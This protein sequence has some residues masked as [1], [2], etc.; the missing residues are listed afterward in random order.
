MTSPYTQLDKQRMTIA[1]QRARLDDLE[2][3]VAALR[4]VLTSPHALDAAH[5]RGRCEVLTHE[6]ALLRA[7]N[8]SWAKRGEG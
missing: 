2:A 5:Y 8:A 6:N 7:A 3:E 1:R 4:A